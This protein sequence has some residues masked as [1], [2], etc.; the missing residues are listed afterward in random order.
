MQRRRMLAT[1]GA[2]LAAGLVGMGAWP[3]PALSETG[4]AAKAAAKAVSG[5]AYD[6]TGVWTNAWYTKLERPKAFK[7]LIVTPA[8]AEAY[9]APRRAH[10]GELITTDDAVGQNESE[11]PDNGPGLARIRGEL[12]SSWIV[13]PADGKVPW[14]PEAK[15]HRRLGLPSDDYDNVEARDT[16]ERCLTNPGTGAPILNDHDA[17]LVQFVQTGDRKTGGA[18]AIY[19]EKNHQVRIAQILAR[20]GAGAGAAPDP[21]AAG[22]T[23]W[24]GASVGHWKGA[25]LVVETTG[26]RPGMTMI[27][28]GL[29]LSDHARVVERFTRSGPPNGPGE[30]AYSFE[31]TD[32]TLFTQPWRGEMVFRP[33]EGQ[34]FEYAC[35]EGNYGLP[36]ILAAARAAEREKAAA[37]P[38]KPRGP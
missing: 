1:L 12:R 14:R 19:G 20:A 35:H 16:E 15:A 5:P 21:R 9:E 26:F 30:I 36:N 17:N 23:E 18:L 33:A 10:Q 27:T 29:L 22:I 37:G 28:R 6:L 24:L 25:T 31:V 4:R 8:E 34:I 11:F 32:E 3:S 2:G 7:D 38:A 13:E